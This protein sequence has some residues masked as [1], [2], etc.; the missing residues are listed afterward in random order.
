MKYYYQLIMWDDCLLSAIAMAWWIMTVDRA[1]IRLP[2]EN[3]HQFFSCGVCF[4]FNIYF[5]FFLQ[6]DAWMISP[7]TMTYNL[8]EIWSLV[9]VTTVAQA[10]ADKADIPNTVSSLQL[11][12]RIVFHKAMQYTPDVLLYHGWSEQASNI[13]N[14]GN[15]LLYAD[16]QLNRWTENEL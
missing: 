14:E 11:H 1:L 4:V 2:L 16:Y 15:Q 13:C 7:W 3:V 6:V 8:I 9:V 12:N 10:A 5:S